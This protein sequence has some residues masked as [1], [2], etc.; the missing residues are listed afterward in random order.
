MTT[1]HEYSTI[2]VAIADGL[3]LQWHHPDGDWQDQTAESMLSEIAFT[4][5]KPERYRV[6][7]KTIN[8][9]GIEVP[10]GLTT[11]PEAGANYWMLN[12]LEQS[13]VRSYCWLGG[14]ADM[15]V[16]NAGQ[17]WSTEADARLASLAI[18]KLFTGR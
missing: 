6:K 14:P 15:H 8:I 7:P 16:L 11:A 4:A 5:Y 13:G 12:A 18:T 2:L 9:A 3:D 17:C 10:A 1:K